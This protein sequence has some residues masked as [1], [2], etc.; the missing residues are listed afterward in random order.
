[1][2]GYAKLRQLLCK[3]KEIRDQLIPKL[4]WEELQLRHIL[5]YAKEKLWLLNFNFII[6][7]IDLSKPLSS[8]DEVCEQ[9]YDYL[10]TLWN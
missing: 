7:S 6:N 1:M 2:H 3:E 5:W 10:T 9:I 4:D 8:Q